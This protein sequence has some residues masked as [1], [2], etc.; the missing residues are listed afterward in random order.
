MQQTQKALGQV[1]RAYSKT[2]THSERVLRQ[3]FY[4][5]QCTYTPNTAH[6]QLQLLCSTSEIKGTHI[7]ITHKYVYSIKCSHGQ[8]FCDP[9]TAITDG[10]AKNGTHDA[11]S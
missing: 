10:L 4:K 3:T 5:Q 7:N 8:C 9:N 2:H 1:V 11:N 6:L